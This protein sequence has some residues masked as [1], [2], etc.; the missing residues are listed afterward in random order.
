MLFYLLVASKWPDTIR[1][2]PDL[3]FSQPILNIYS[4]YRRWGVHGHWLKYKVLLWPHHTLQFLPIDSMPGT[5][6]NGSYCSEGSDHKPTKRVNDV[7]TQLLQLHLYMYFRECDTIQK[8][9]VS[10]TIFWYT[11]CHE[12]RRRQSFSSW[13]ELI[14]DGDSSTC[15]AMYN[16][17]FVT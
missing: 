10:R 3:N 15:G 12:I 6:Q 1:I 5:F 9:S 14:T 11:H 13:L 8:Q 4:Q 17:M 2:T 16:Y 7:A